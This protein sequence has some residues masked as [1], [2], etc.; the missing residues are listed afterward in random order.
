VLCNPSHSGLTVIPGTRLLEDPL[1]LP[2]VYVLDPH[3]PWRHWWVQWV[4]A[5]VR[6]RA[7]SGIRAKLIDT[8]GFITF[9]N[10]RDLEVIL[11]HGEPGEF[12][13]WTG[14]EYP[15]PHDPEW[16]GLCCDDED[17]RDDLFEYECR[18]REQL[19]G[20]PYLPQG[21]EYR[22]RVHFDRNY[23]AEEL[24]TLLWDMNPDTG[25]YPDPT[26][27][28]VQRR[29]ARVERTRVAWERL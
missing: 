17:L 26:L 24:Y 29:W 8:K 10:Q 14:K 3:E 1:G 13:K 5:P 25:Q 27:G 28:T 18:V 6:G 4:L 15:G 20:Y 9:C 2:G 7:L 19:S 23:D 21:L 11:R 22:R 16:Y 12:C